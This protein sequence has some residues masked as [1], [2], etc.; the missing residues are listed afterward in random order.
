MNLRDAI[1]VET[2][3]FVN[4]MEFGE[5]VRWSPAGGGVTWITA[6]VTLESD[7]QDIGEMIEMDGV[8]GFLDVRESAVPGI[9]KDDSVTVRGSVYRVVGEEPDGEGMVRIKIGI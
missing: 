3:A 9:G 2:A 1:A 8:A 7:V 4:E 5:A 6:I